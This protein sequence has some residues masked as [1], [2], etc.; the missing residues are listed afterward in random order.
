VTLS[1]HRKPIILGSIVLN[2]SIEANMSL[3]GKKCEIGA[4]HKPSFGLAGKLITFGKYI[5]D[6]LGSIEC[7]RGVLLK[8][9]AKTNRL[10]DLVLLREL[11]DVGESRTLLIRTILSH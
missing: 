6:L 4:A 10:K 1:P 9:R 2:L 5:I 8:Q 3:I 11:Q 7:K